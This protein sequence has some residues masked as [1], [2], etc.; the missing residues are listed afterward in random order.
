M[1]KNEVLWDAAKAVLKW[2]NLAI[3][4]R[5]D[6]SVFFGFFTFYFEVIVLSDTSIRSNTEKCCIQKN[7]S[8]FSPVV[9]FCI[10]RVKFHSLDIDAI[11]WKK[12]KK[13]FY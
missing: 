6:F 8:F 9:T 4:S 12:K 5:Q 2:I 13:R 11:Y 10:T 7:V 1:N 3:L